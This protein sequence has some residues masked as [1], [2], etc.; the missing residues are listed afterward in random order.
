MKIFTEK[1][2]EKYVDEKM[3]QIREREICLREIDRMDAEHYK[4]AVRV[5]E[6]ERLV[7]EIRRKHSE[8]HEVC[9]AIR[10]S[11]TIRIE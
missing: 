5:E 9:E 7:D 2:L 6:L 11:G 1:A 10:K 3:R 4:L 8:D